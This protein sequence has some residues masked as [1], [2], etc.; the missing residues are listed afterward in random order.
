MQTLKQLEISFKDLAKNKQL[1]HAYLFHGAMPS[2]QFAFAKKLAGYLEVGRWEF[3]ERLLID[4]MVVDELGETISIETSRSFLPFLSLSPAQSE[5]RTLIVSGAKEL[6]TQAQNAI[7]KVVEEPPPH[8]LIILIV[9]EIG[10]LLPALLSR[11]QKVYFSEFGKSE[12]ELSELDK[13]AIA[14]AKK[15][16]AAA[17]SR[18]RSEMLKVIVKEDELVDN[19]VRAL[20]AEMAKKPMQY[21]KALQELL[22]RNA[23]MQQLSTNRKLQLEAVL[24]YLE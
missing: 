19:F 23:L 5:Y 14:L 10:V 4:A 24:Q 13:E 15:F 21:S 22:H 9:Q 6:T 3:P 7:L 12:E 18:E 11:F 8:A 20:I 16:I 17:S 1:A 2:A